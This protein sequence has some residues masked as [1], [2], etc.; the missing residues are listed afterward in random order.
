[1]RTSM[2]VHNIARIEIEKKP[3]KLENL[4][5]ANKIRIT[6]ENGCILDITL[7]SDNQNTLK[8]KEN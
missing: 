4:T 7:F 5:Y 2:S 1:M 8:I 3:V 6:D